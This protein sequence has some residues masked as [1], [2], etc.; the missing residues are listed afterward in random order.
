MRVGV[1]SRWGLLIAVLSVITHTAYVF[2]V[3]P[4]LPAELRGE[5]QRVAMSIVATG[6]FANPYLIDTGPTAHLPPVQPYL[7][8]AI[9]RTFGTGPGGE[10]V[11]QT[12]NAVLLAVRNG[13]MPAL[14][15]AMGLPPAVGILAGLLLVYPPSLS[16]VYSPFDDPVSGLLLVLVL[17]AAGRWGAEPK[18]ALWKRIVAGMLWG[19]AILS[20]PALVM[21]MVALTAGIWLTRTPGTRATWRRLLPTMLACGL[22]LTPWSIRNDRLF[23]VG[24]FVRDN[25]GLELFIGNN[26]GA[27]ADYRQAVGI[28]H[29]NVDLDEALRV[30]EVGEVMYHHAKLREALAWIGQHP[31]RAAALAAGRVGHFWFPVDAGVRHGPVIWVLTLLSIPGV[32]LMWRWSRLAGI[33]VSLTLALYPLVYYLT[34][35]AFRYRHAVYPLTVLAAACAIWQGARRLGFAVR[36]PGLDL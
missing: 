28:R 2:R 7:L 9:Y 4:P 18:T 16:A 14:A 25:L 31:G 27:A 19:A 32:V 6:A 22:V 10:R 34:Q 20:S 11:R 23:H 5:P 8:S 35:A 26:D 12:F 3:V 1:R 15:G 29:P 17:L 33:V 13:L 30:R 36:L 24:F 21:A